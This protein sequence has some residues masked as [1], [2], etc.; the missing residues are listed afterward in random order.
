MREKKQCKPHDIVITSN[1]VKIFSVKKTLRERYMSHR[2]SL[3][4]KEEQRSC[5]TARF[6][7]S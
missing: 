5:R 4:K 3:L 7:E 1:L 6:G 2:G